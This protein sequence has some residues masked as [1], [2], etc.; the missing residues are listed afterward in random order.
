MN[1]IEKVAKAINLDPGN[2]EH[3][4]I[5]KAAIEAMREPTPEMLDAVTA[6]DQTEPFSNATVSG[7]FGEMIDAALEHK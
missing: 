2:M 7:M 6:A 1:M 4:N 3:R 5:A